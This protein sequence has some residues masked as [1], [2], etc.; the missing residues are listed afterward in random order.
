M[1][2]FARTVMIVSAMAAAIVF[3]LVR[4]EGDPA[5]GDYR[6][7]DPTFIVIF[8]VTGDST[9]QPTMNFRVMAH[10]KTEGEAVMR[11]VLAVQRE[12]G[13]NATDKLVFIEVAQKKETGK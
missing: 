12:F 6:I 2:I 7:T 4:Q 3:P 8:N 10:A 11:A 9:K 13:I 1:M 5:P